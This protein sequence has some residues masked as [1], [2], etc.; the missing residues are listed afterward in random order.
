MWVAVLALAGGFAVQ[1]G[2]GPAVAAPAAAAAPT[3]VHPTLNA[4]GAPAPGRLACRAVVRT[5]YATPAVVAADGTTVTPA[6]IAGYGPGDLQSAYQLP[7]GSVGAGQT[8]AIVDAFD[9][10]TAESDMNTYRSQYG[11]PACTTANGCFRKI[12]ENGGTSY[13]SP[14]PQHGWGAETALDLDMVSA[15]CPN[16]K[17]LLVEAAFATVNDLGVGVNTAVSLGAKY[18]SNG[19]GSAES[20]DNSTYDAK[21][22]NHPGVAITAAAGDTGYGV[23]YPAASRYVT[24]VGGTS[25]SRASN[26]R[27]WAETVWSGTGSGC[28]N[29]DAMPSWQAQVGCGN[30][31]VT[32]VSAVADP[33][34]GVAMYDS[35]PDANNQSGWRVAGGTSASAALIA[36]I[37]ALAGEPGANTYPASYLYSHSWGAW[38]FNDITSGSNGSCSACNAQ[39]GYDQPSGLGTPIGADAFGVTTDPIAQY[40]ISLGG[41]TSYLGDPTGPVTL[42]GVVPG[43]VGEY[44]RYQNGEIVYSQRTGAHVLRGAI[45]DKYNATGGPGGLGF[46]TSDE[47]TTADGKARYNTFSATGGSAIYWTPNDGAYEIKGAIYAHWMSLGGEASVLGYPITDETNGTPDGATRFNAFSN[48]AEIWWSASTGTWSIR[49]AIRGKWVSTGYELGLP[50]SDETVTPDGVGRYN[51]FANDGSIYWTP[52]TGVWSVHGLIRHQ[53]ASMGWERGPLGYPTSDEYAV[54]DGRQNNFQYGTITWHSTT[55]TI[56]VTYN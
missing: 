23:E 38:S 3:P 26:T 24:A 30:R 35:T 34:T 50:T 4:C 8:V 39:T 5:D 18:I 47:L 55:N 44:Q 45:L 17:I 20:S 41:T 42:M 6:V 1:L 15:A 51:H 7:T 14:D 31:T 53:W 32:D 37:Y 19:Y 12:D 48:Y 36:G 29:W 49:G 21:Y 43:D 2:S 56:N 16:C 9:L 33:Q 27:G 13:P 10:P 28:S 22:F 25:L 52:G 46:P 54:P 11:L 40:Y